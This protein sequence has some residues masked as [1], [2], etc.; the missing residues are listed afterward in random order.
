M[1]KNKKEELMRPR[2]LLEENQLQQTELKQLGEQLLDQQR[3]QER[4][5][6]NNKKDHS[7][8]YCLFEVG[9]L[10][11]QTFLLFSLE[12]ES[13]DFVTLTIAMAKSGY[14]SIELSLV[15]DFMSL[16]NLKIYLMF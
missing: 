9:K 10:S 5:N 16:L 13:V 2:K 12:L 7:K 3:S 6:R 14:N 8:C 15:E 1:E 4:S 11:L